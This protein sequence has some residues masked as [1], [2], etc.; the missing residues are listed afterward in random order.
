MDEVPAQRANTLLP[1]GRYIMGQQLDYEINKELGECYLF[2]GDLDKAET[3]YRKA[4]NCAGEYA[5]SYLGLATIA[6]QRGQ[7]ENALTLYLKAVEKNGGDKALT[8]A[9]LVY[10][11]L[12]EHDKAMDHFEQALALNPENT[13]AL[14]CFVRIVYARNCVDRIVPVLEACLEA[15]PASEAYRITLAGCLMTVGRQDKAR[16]YLLSVLETNPASQDARELYEHI[17]A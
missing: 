14:N 1:G 4:A 7:Y 12:G 17:A 3:Y 2:M 15:N 5:D 16:E 6:V 10:M 9:G 13:V 8:G 11:E